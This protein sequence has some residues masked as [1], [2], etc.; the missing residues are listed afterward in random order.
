MI[1]LSQC[2]DDQLI[3]ELENRGRINKYH[4]AEIRLGDFSMKHTMRCQPDLFNCT[5]HKWL[6]D[7][8]V[9]NR[10]LSPIADGTYTIR[11]IKGNFK[12]TPVKGE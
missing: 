2:T 9:G 7:Q 12:L 8:F 1:D 10:G 6:E 5:I 3:T 4:I 11:E